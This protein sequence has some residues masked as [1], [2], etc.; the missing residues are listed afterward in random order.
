MLNQKKLKD[1]L[2]DSTFIFD[3]E[4][5]NKSPIPGEDGMIEGSFTDDEGNPV[6]GKSKVFAPDTPV[7]TIPKY[8]VWLAKKSNA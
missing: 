6:A 1:L 4:I 7:Y 5:F 3:G 2:S 8:M